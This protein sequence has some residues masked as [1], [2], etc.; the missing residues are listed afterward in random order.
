MLLHG[1]LFEHLHRGA[2]ARIARGFA[3]QMIQRAIARGGDDPAG[4]RGRHTF[5][6]P[7]HQRFREGVL[8]RLLGEIDVTEE[9]HQDRDRASVLAAEYCCDLRAQ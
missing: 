2:L 8:H 7:A 1:F 6:R 9:A 3:A 4:R 5:L